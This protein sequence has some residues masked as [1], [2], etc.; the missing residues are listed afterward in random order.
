[1]KYQAD[2]QNISTVNFERESKVRLDG[3]NYTFDWQFDSKI[4]TK[5]ME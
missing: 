3:L 5:S 1:M 4:E 2:G